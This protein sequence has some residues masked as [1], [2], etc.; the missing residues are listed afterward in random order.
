MLNISKNTIDDKIDELSYT[1]FGEVVTP[2]LHKDLRWL[3]A[4][5]GIIGIIFAFL[6]WTQ[7]I[8]SNGTVTTLRPEQ[9]PQQ[10]MSPIPAR[11]E[12][13]F[14]REGEFVEKGDTLI[15]ISEIKAEY[16][17][18]ELVERTKEQLQAKKMSVE[19]YEE[20]IKSYNNQIDALIE[21]RDL[22][23]KQADNK[24]Q[25]AEL[26]LQRDSLDLK[27]I[28]NEYQIAQ[29]QLKRMETMLEQGL[30]TQVDYEK[31]N[32][33]LQ[34]TEAKF[35]GQQAKVRETINDLYNAQIEITNLTN[36]YEEKLSKIRADRASAMSMRLQSETE[37]AKNR[38]LVRNYE[39][40]RDMY[41]IR[42]PQSGYVTQ[43]LTAGLGETIKEG[44]PI[45]SIMPESYDLAVSA[46]VQPLDLPLLK[47]GQDVRIQFDG[48]PAIV[49]SG[50]EN[51]SYGTYGGEVVAIDNFANEKGQYRILIGPDPEE[52]PW[53]DAL[54][55]GGGAL[56]FTLLNDVPLWYEIWRQFN[57]FP[58]DFYEM[59]APE[60]VN[61]IK[62]P[63]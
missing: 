57:G 34:D 5:L 54:R 6:P 28:E 55:P 52:Y 59:D 26:K 40:R 2:R 36:E 7:N 63:K 15:F 35:L 50:W 12:K 61:K 53:P 30:R 49:F 8:R 23:L 62:L 21:V 33:K 41:H 9:R 38:N 58:P 22:K 25:Q 24:L 32:V 43:A 18:P 4:A 11:I 60:K 14:V 27:A 45:L 13:W 44:T 1:S 29:A 17:D 46:Y 47:L 37:V 42:A 51:V 3:F 10:V 19:A 16:L 20:K 48:W 31:R 56:T 39:Q